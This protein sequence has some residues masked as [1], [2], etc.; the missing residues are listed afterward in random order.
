[1][2]SRLLAAGLVLAAAVVILGLTADGGEPVATLRVV[3]HQNGPDAPSQTHTIACRDGTGAVCSR[4]AAH[5]AGDFAPAPRDAICTQIYGGPATATIR[6]TLHGE[7]LDV[8]L[9][10]SN[11]CAIDRWDRFAWLL[12]P[13]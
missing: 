6:G 8:R 7:E 10:R 4:L 3:V 13:R 11:G 12:Q 2:R 5:D 1:M 9:D